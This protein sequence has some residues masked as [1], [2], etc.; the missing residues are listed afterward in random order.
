MRLSAFLFVLFRLLLIPAF[1]AST[2]L[3]LY[4]AFSRCGF[5]KATHTRSATAQNDAPRP[6]TLA[7]FRLLALGDP[8]LEG[9]T[10]L[11]DP[12]EPLLPSLQR[13]WNDAAGLLDIAQALVK[14]DIWR[15]LYTARKR[16]DLWGNDYYLAH[17]YRSL[18]WWTRPTHT[19][20]LGD[21]LGSQWIGD[22]EFEIRRSRFWNIVFRGGERVPETLTK[23]EGRTESL[24]ADERWSRRV[25]AVAGNHDIGYAGDISEPR[26]ERFEK[27][28]GD[29]N[30]D[31][32]FTLDGEV[33]TPI[34]DAQGVVLESQRPSLHLVIL[35]SMNLDQP[36]YSAEL[37][38]ASLAF[39]EEK[40]H[41]PAVEPSSTTATVLLTHIPLHKEAGICVDGPFFNYFDERYGGGIQEQNHL[42]EHTSSLILEGLLRGPQKRQSIILNGHDHEGCDTYH[43]AERQ[44]MQEPDTPGSD[45]ELPQIHWEAS[46]FNSAILKAENA[47][48]AALREITVRS[49]MGSFGGNAGLLS[50]W[51]DYEI[52]EWRFEYNSCALGVQHIW[53]AIHI[54]DLIV[55]IIGMLGAFTLYLERRVVGGIKVKTA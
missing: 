39:L 45:E 41:S 1:I 29:V 31:I 7:P 37:R 23:A 21:L 32:R 54:L 6:S 14:N 44:Q 50:A 4:P 42:S 5:P 35:N 53:W 46:R 52:N 55:I 20:V 2:Y 22:E 33:G 26:I 24:G 51:F 47:D 9:D 15:I 38:E 10:S 49:M 34:V 19:V 16:L 27:A 18:S 48:V 43:W 8:Q 3:Y 17:I 28:F 30:W 12:N 13:P 25:I 11:P 36:G 40:I